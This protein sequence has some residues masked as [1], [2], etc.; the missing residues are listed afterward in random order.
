M[1][2]YFVIA[3]CCVL[4]LLSCT[5]IGDIDV[6]PSEIEVHHFQVTVKYAGKTWYDYGVLMLPS[7]YNIN[8]STTDLIIYCHSGGG[9]VSKN[10]S[11]CENMLYNMYLVSQGYS[12]LSMA[13]MPLEY[14]QM[15]EIDQYRTVGSEIS[16]LCT[17]A[18]YKYVLENYSFSDN[19]FLLSNSNGGLLA[20]NL[21]HFSNISFKAQSGIAPLLSI[22]NNAWIIQSGANSGGKHA[23]YQNRD[24][25]ISLYGMSPVSNTEELISKKYEKNKVGEF[26]PYDYYMNQT[27]L[28]YK[29]P[30]LIFSCVADVTVYNSLSTM[31]AEEMVKRGSIVEVDNSTSYGAHNVKAQPILVGSFDYLGQ[32]YET[33]EVFAKIE[34]FFRKYAE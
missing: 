32:T 31:F 7:G 26:D 10:S 27:D 13:S 23:K 11:E 34:S 22:E 16:I 8:S 12:V 14:A 33:N 25:I 5:S 4:S 1:Y 21:V 9:T 20:S 6:I 17:E 3:L 19:V 30:Y 28:A 15:L 24:N 29:V 18:G 2:R